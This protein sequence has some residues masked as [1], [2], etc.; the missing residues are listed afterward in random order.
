MSGDFM[1]SESEEG[2]YVLGGEIEPKE[3]KSISKSDRG[4]IKFKK[5]V[6]K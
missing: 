3:I 4:G 5:E 2:D 6:S 1:I